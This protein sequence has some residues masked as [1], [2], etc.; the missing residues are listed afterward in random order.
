MLYNFQQPS[1]F[2]ISQPV[3][4]VSHI[5][6]MNPYQMRALPAAFQMPDGGSGT[7][8]KEDEKEHAEELADSADISLEETPGALLLATNPD[9]REML[10]LFM[11]PDHEHLLRI[12]SA[13]RLHRGVTEQSLFTPKL[14]S[15]S[16]IDLIRLEIYNITYRFYHTPLGLRFKIIC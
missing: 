6:G 13:I 14:V 7:D 16:R 3:E 5:P 4:G 8:D 12:R 15:D 1:S 11:I 2:A 10:N 9:F